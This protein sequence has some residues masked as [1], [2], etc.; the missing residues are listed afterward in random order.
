MH[1]RNTGSIQLQMECKSQ[2]AVIFA[3]MTVVALHV[4]RVVHRFTAGLSVSVKRLLDSHQWHLPQCGNHA[5]Q[6]SPPCITIDAGT[7]QG[8]QMFVCI[9]EVYA[10]DRL[11]Q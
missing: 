6:E 11:R 8:M 3:Q 2:E 1:V 10:S 9:M 5:V 4:Y 7:K